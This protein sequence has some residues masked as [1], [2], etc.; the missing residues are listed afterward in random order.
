MPTRRSLLY[1]ALQEAAEARCAAGFGQDAPVSSFDL[2]TALGANVWFVD[3][4]MEGIYDRGPPARVLLSPYRPL[5]RRMFTCAHETGHHRFGHGS[6]VS[7]LRKSI[8]DRPPADAPEEILAHAFASFVLMPPLGIDRAFSRRGVAP[9]N[10]RPTQV[11]AIACDF[12]VGY[13]TML[14]HLAYGL[15][16]IS[17]RRRRDLERWKLPELRRQI[18]GYADSTP[19]VVID[20][21][22]EATSIE[23]EIGYGI[24]APPRST[25]SNGALLLQS[26][27]PSGALFRAKRRG[28]TRLQAGGR[29]IDI[30]TMPHQYIGQARFRYLE[31]PDGTS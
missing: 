30:R 7:E 21:E 11:F 1:A 14:T 17:E 27:G 6:T 23:V 24:Y 22:G 20:E 29:A 2:A 18:L 16:E 10:A 4:D 3:I 5:S 28:I 31:E 12:G 13:T 15:S 25:V 26:T 8:E 9:E 19:L